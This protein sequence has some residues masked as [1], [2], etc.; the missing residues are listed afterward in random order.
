[1]QHVKPFLILIA[2]ACLFGVAF[3]APANELLARRGSE[4]LEDA[5][6]NVGEGLPDNVTSALDV[7]E[8]AGKGVNGGVG[9]LRNAI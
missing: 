7:I 8:T 9:G 1:M 2:L 5:P 3:A 4:L 6:K